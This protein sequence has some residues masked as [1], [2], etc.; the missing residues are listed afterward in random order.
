[1]FIRD[2]RRNP[3]DWVK[4]NRGLENVLIPIRVRGL[5]HRWVERL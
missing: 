4:L 1:M 3:K 2:S 5:F